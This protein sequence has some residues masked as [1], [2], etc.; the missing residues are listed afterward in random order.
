MLLSDILKGVGIIDT[1]LKNTAIEISGISTDS[2]SA[3]MGNVFVCI[4][5]ERVDSHEARYVNEALSNGVS[6]VITDRDIDVTC[7]VIKVPDT[8]KSLALMCGNYYGRPQDKLKITAVTGTNGKTT[9]THMLKAIYEEAGLK[10]AVIGTVTNEMTTPV[11]QQLY[12][13]LAEF[14]ESGVEYV[15]IE[16]SSHALSLGRLEKIK[17]KYG[18]FTNLTQEHLDFHGTMEEYLK[19]KAILF[20]QCGIGII[21]YDDEYS[22]DLSELAECEMLYYSVNDNSDFSAG[23]IKNLGIDG[24]RF[25]FFAA[26]EVFRL[27]IPI[28]GMFTVYNSLAAVSCAYHDG[29]APAIIRNALKKFQGVPG[30]LEFLRNDKNLNIFIDYAHTPDALEN[31]LKVLRNIRNSGKLIV[32]FGCGGDRDNTKRLV[33]GKIASRLADFVIVTSDNSRTEDPKKIINDIMKGIDKEV[34]HIVIENRA[35]AIKYA[36]D[37]AK[38]NDIILLAGKGHEKYEITADGKHPFNEKELVYKFT[39][40]EGK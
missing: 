5:G 1:N 20:S 10:C 11:P 27:T 24:V 33:M 31:V 32:L 36:V 29:V 38:K 4:K 16:A 21:N 9:V 2:R 23:N 19:A 30:R 13:L 6:V 14:V 28:P 40:A 35:E 26:C 37:I 25:D 12:P 17:F 15:F 18:I 39:S 8:H 34:P 3:E 7:M 22:E